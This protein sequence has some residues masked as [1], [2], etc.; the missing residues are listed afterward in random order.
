MINAD[1]RT[2][3]GNAVRFFLY[4]IIIIFKIINKLFGAIRF[5]YYLCSVKL[6]TI[7]HY[8]TDNTY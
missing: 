7:N 3:L 8:G 5:F 1:R 4:K 6:K 2:S